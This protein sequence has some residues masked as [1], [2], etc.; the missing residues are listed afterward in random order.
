[1]NHRILPFRRAWWLVSGLL[2]AG[3]A[4]VW[5]FILDPV[6]VADGNETGQGT[7]DRS[8][9]VYSEPAPTRVASSRQPH[10]NAG[11]PV[12][13]RFR[14]E[15]G[16]FVLVVLDAAASWDWEWQMDTAHAALQQ[17]L[18]PMDVRR[19][20]LVLLDFDLSEAAA[21]IRTERYGGWGDGLDLQRRMKFP[22][23]DYYAFVALNPYEG[24]DWVY[25][26]EYMDGM[27][28]AHLGLIAKHAGTTEGRDLLHRKLV[29]IV[30]DRFAVGHGECFPDGNEAVTCL[31]APV[32][33]SDP[34]LDPLA[35]N[36][37]YFIMLSAWK[38]ALAARHDDRE[39]RAETKTLWGVEV[40][41]YAEVRYA[42]TDTNQIEPEFEGT[43]HLV[44]AWSD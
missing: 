2:S 27:R 1:M 41:A 40:A 9:H 4:L 15:E 29:G 23:S 30:P 22:P 33:N 3:I 16:D 32:W 20:S 14:H 5:L 13:K 19:L 28:L 25:Q 10:A 11:L 26:T 8:S 18:Y 39:V 31:V 43:P 21:R 38:T 37:L 42:V 36:L 6:P 7:N 44:L 24:N 12:S 34:N 17:L 35:G